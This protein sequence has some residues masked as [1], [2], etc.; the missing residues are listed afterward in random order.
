MV[1]DPGGVGIE[2]NGPKRRR[3]RVALAIGSNV[4]DRL[5]NLRFAVAHLRGLLDPCSLSGVYETAPLYDRDQPE[6]LNACCT[7]RTRLSARQLLSEL[8]HIERLAGRTR[9]RRYGP[10]TLDLDLLLYG[11]AVIEQPN[12]I[13]PHPRMHERRFVLEPLR[14][15]AGDWIVPSR[16][17]REGAS[18][19]E[20]ADAL[21]SGMV[22]RTKL[23]LEDG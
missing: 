9:G 14:E 10:R 11:D 12:L 6:F 16:S 7:G 22:E 15:I 20:L 18:V 1:G 17:G 8:Q 2:Q 5:A 3:T 21:A 4:G 13:V 19:E 23:R